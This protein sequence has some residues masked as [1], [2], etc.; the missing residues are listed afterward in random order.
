VERLIMAADAALADTDQT[1]SRD[2]RILVARVLSAA[3]NASSVWGSAARTGQWAD[4]AVM[5]AREAGDPRTLAEALSAQTMVAV[6]S[7]QTKLVRDAYEEANRLAR[8]LGDWWTVSMIE[9]GAAL[10][11]IANGDFE[12][13]EGRLRKATE[14]AERS[15]NPYTIAFVALSRGRISGYAS[16]LP[17]A[18]HWFGEAIAAYEQM[19]DRR[20]ILVARSDL[21]HALRHGGAIDEAEA[22]YRDTLHEWQH[23]GSRGAIANQL[24]SFGIIAI[25]RKEGLRAARLMGAAES[26][27]ELAGT[28][29]LEFER[30]EYEAALVPLH[31]LLDPPALESAWAE[32]RRLSIDQA[33]ALALLANQ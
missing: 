7:G 16:R 28:P 20:F 26:I 5:L 25:T 23:L 33:I 12:G 13:A 17:E 9:G 6:F 18:R 3:A 24:E 21:A 19:N 2:R 8:E 1:P 29:M 30:R 15:G 22:A 31:E 4:R 32:G 14:A 27:R 10:D 11:D